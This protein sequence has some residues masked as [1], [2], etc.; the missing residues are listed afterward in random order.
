MNSKLE[1]KSNPGY[2]KKSYLTL[3]NPKANLEKKEDE[4]DLD[5]ESDLGNEKSNLNWVV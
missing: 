3:S 4:L 2:L 5:L 1:I